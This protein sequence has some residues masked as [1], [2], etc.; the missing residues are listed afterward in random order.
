MFRE[1][2]NRTNCESFS[3]MLVTR[4]LPYFFD[5]HILNAIKLYIALHI[6]DKCTKTKL[7]KY[8]FMYSPRVCLQ[9]MS[10]H[11]SS[12]WQFAPPLLPPVKKKKSTCTNLLLQTLIFSSKTSSWYFFALISDLLCLAECRFYILWLLGCCIVGNIVS[13]FSVWSWICML[14]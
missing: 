1:N 2:V 9:M 5:F 13:L 12:E 10:V 4:L 8:I 3:V 7:L 6:D 11:I 14:T